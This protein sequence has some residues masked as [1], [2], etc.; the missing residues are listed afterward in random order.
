M[1]VLLFYR[2][3]VLL[4]RSSSFARVCLLLRAPHRVC[5]VCHVCRVSRAYR[6]TTHFCD[7][8]HQNAAELITADKRE[9]P[10]CTCKIDHPPNGEEF[11][12]GCSYCRFASLSFPHTYTNCAPPHTR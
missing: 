7:A 3:L 9:L 11:S 1:S 8:C 5:R 2:C 10:A 12:L 4:V 6:G